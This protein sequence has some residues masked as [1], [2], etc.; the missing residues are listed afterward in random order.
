MQLAREGVQQQATPMANET[1]RKGADAENSEHAL[2]TSQPIISWRQP[3]RA[4]R[5]WCDTKV[6][7]HVLATGSA[8]APSSRNASAGARQRPHDRPAPAPPGAQTFWSASRRDS[9]QRARETCRR[10]RRRRRRPSTAGKPAPV[11][12]RSDVPRRA[13]MP[14]IGRHA[15]ARKRTELHTRTA[16]CIWPGMPWPPKEPWPGMPGAID[17]IGYAI[18]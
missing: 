3:L 13:S 9:V 2:R 12:D 6:S 4:G 10:R 7:G 17:C 18:L 1:T 5:V 15:P 16:T 8:R 11:S 14:T